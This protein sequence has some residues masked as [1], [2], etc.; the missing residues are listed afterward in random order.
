MADYIRAYKD[1]KSLKFYE[2]NDIASWFEKNDA[3][4]SEEEK[5]LFS[6]ISKHIEIPTP[7]SVDIVQNQISQV[8][9]KLVNESSTIA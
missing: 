3:S 1:V 4:L 9:S 5:E 2:S 7:L 8:F 6:I